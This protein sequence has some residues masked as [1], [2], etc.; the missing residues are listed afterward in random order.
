LQRCFFREKENRCKQL[1][2]ANKELTFQ[3][4]KEKRANELLPL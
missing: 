1:S 3:N 4:K 2:I